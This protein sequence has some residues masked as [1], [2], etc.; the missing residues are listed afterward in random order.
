MMK[1]LSKLLFLSVFFL[2]LTACKTFEVTSQRTEIT[3][4][5]GDEY[6]CEYVKGST[7][8]CKRKDEEN[9]KKNLAFVF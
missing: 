7:I 5:E 8:N 6:Y 4:I 3:T 1:K 9:E 2:M